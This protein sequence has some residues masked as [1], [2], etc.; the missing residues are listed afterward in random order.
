MD[1][2]AES[3]RDVYDAISWYNSNF[4]ALGMKNGGGDLDTLRHVYTLLLGLGMRESSGEY[5]C[6][7]D[8][9]ATN[10]SSDSAEAGA[11]Q[12]SYDS[13]GANAELPKL[14]ALYKTSSHPN[15]FL[16]T[17]KAGI[18]CSA[19][20]LKNWG[21]GEGYAFQALEKDCPA[22]AAEYA[23]IMLRVA[24]GKVGHYGPI[25]QKAAEIKPEC[26]AMLSKVQSLVLSNES[27]CDALR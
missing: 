27:Y 13:H 4:A 5:C 11:W 23:A 18:S 2:V 26:D 12:T 10:T 8:A 6:G 14:F 9:S 22:F 24:G 1:N 7:R 15:C 25:R 19:S 16:D 21:S 20:N 17:F 3:T